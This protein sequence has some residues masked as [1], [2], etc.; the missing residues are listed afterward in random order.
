MLRFAVH[1]EG[2]LGC[3]EDYTAQQIDASVYASGQTLN[4]DM[5]SNQEFQHTKARHA[6]E[7]LIVVVLCGGPLHRL[8]VF[9]MHPQP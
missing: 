7:A 1:R 6:V 4:T 8:P 2:G 9:C 5:L 3:F